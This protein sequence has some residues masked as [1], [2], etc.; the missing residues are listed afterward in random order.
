MLATVTRTF[1]QH[2]IINSSSCSLVLEDLMLAATVIDIF[3]AGM[4]TTAMTLLWTILY[5]VK[6]PEIQERIYEE[7]VANVGKDRLPTW[8]DRES[9]P[10]LEATINEVWRLPSLVPQGV[11]HVALSDFWFGPYK[12]PKVIQKSSSVQVTSFYYQ[13]QK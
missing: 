2:S 8:S 11:Q 7:I 1:N 13:H 12:I 4:Q 10:Y 9:L 6:Y 5:L 3:G